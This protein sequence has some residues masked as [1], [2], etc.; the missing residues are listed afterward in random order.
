VQY[1]LGERIF[2]VPGS[3]HPFPPLWVIVGRDGVRVVPTEFDEVNAAARWWE[4][5]AAGETAKGSR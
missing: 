4:D 5:Q 1:Q 2:I 3:N